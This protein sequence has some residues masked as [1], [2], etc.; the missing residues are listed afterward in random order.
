DVGIIDELAPANSDRRVGGDQLS[1]GENLIAFPAKADAEKRAPVA[2]HIEP[3]VAGVDRSAR[4]ASPVF[5]N[6]VDLMDASLSAVDS[7]NDLR[8][9]TPRD[10]VETRRVEPCELTRVS[11]SELERARP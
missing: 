5:A 2:G 4:D 6:P 9:R 7:D 8:L 3:L 11:S 10:R 1:G